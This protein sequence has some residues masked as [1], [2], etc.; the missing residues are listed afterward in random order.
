MDTK[1]SIFTS[2]IT[3]REIVPV[4]VFMSAIKFSLTLKKSYILYIWGYWFLLH[5]EISIFHWK[6]W[7]GKNIRI[8]HE[9]LCRIGKSY[10]R[11][12]NFNQRRGFQSP[13]LKFRTPTNISLSYINWLMMDHFLPFLLPFKTNNMHTAKQEKINI[14]LDSFM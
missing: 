14:L 9:C 7:L 1:T 2:D 4:L 10:P 12:R 3:T 6:A 11:G 13:W 8:H 5:W